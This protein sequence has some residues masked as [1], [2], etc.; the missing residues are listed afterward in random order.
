MHAIAMQGNPSIK[1]TMLI[2][3]IARVPLEVTEVNQS[4]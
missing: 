1:L 2:Y 4:Q 3:R